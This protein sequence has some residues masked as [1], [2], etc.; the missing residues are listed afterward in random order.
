MNLPLICVLHRKLCNAHDHYLGYC[1]YA[2]KI[3]T[4][5]TPM[6]KQ[7]PKLNCGSSLVSS[8]QLRLSSGNMIGC[9]RGE[10]CWAGVYVD[11]ATNEIL[12]LHAG[13]RVF[14]SPGTAAADTQRECLRWWAEEDLLHMA[15]R[16]D[17]PFTWPG[18]VSDLR[19]HPAEAGKLAGF[20]GKVSTK[21]DADRREG[22][23]YTN[24]TH[25]DQTHLVR[26]PFGFL[27]PGCVY[28]LS[29]RPGFSPWTENSRDTGVVVNKDGTIT[30][31]AGGGRIARWFFG[32]ESSAPDMSDASWVSGDIVVLL[33]DADHDQVCTYRICPRRRCH[34]PAE[35]KTEMRA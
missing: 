21:L 8:R 3:N 2:R 35:T 18:A 7:A 31:V 6:T 16:Y 14:L 27:F 13:G 33:V 20:G 25:V 10:S 4:R 32:G 26:D 19:R 15:D 5:W 1:P 28:A 24:S 22:S 17:Q 11:R 12:H 34:S 23:A 29:V 9:L 30:G